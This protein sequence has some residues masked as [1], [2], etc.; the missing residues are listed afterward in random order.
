VSSHR[1]RRTFLLSDLAFLV[2]LA[3]IARAV[4][5]QIHSSGALLSIRHGVCG[6]LMGL[7]LTVAVGTTMVGLVHRILL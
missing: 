6:G 1:R 2:K 3:T 5:L 4:L 7:E